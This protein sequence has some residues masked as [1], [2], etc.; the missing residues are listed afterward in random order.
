M[1]NDYQWHWAYR[2]AI[3]ISILIFSHCLNCR[4]LKPQLFAQPHQ[5]PIKTVREAV[6]TPFTF[7]NPFGVAT[8]SQ[9]FFDN[10]KRSLSYMNLLNTAQA[11]DNVIRDHIKSTT[12]ITPTYLFSLYLFTKIKPGYTQ[13]QQPHVFTTWF[14][15]RVISQQLTSTVY[16]ILNNVIFHKKYRQWS[17]FG[18]WFQEHD[19]TFG[20]STNRQNRQICQYTCIQK[21][22]NA[23]RWTISSHRY[24][25]PLSTT[26]FTNVDTT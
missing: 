19:V 25:R 2:Y 8:D 5:I 20:N 15:N 11:V 3:A 18:L 16:I 7:S 23:L 24:R 1:Y 4:R 14:Q 21:Q 9:L 26:I 6:L 22:L 10:S 13:F 12:H 17:T